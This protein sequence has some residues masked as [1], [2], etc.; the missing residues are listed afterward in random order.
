MIKQFRSTALSLVSS[1]D[2]VDL[3]LRFTVLMFLLHGGNS[4]L[5]IVS[6]RMICLMIL[7][8][9]N[10]LRRSSVWFILCVLVIGGNALNWLTIDNHKYLFGYWC[11]TCW[12]AV[13]AVNCAEILARS[14]RVLIAAVFL[15]AVFWKVACGEYLDGTFFYW[16]L[17]NDDRLVHLTAWLSDVSIASVRLAARSWSDWTMEAQSGAVVPLAIDRAVLNVALVMGWFGLAIEGSI[18]LL[19]SFSSERL[20]GARHAA[21]I[22]FILST[23]F[24][25]PVIGFAFVLAVMGLAQTRPDDLA[26]RTLYVCLLFAI[27]LIN[28]PWQAVIFTSFR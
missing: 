19:Y 5:Q 22:V 2:G 8:L 12:L 17:K 23:Y 7:A 14:A 26:R 21:L 15:L 3:S 1:N 16:T 20:Y 18:A 6:L 9:P 10:L 27:Q 28:M 4:I 13:S 25:L 11:L 24:L